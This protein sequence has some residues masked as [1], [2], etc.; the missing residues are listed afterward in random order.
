[1][2]LLRRAMS[3]ATKRYAD[4]KTVLECVSFARPVSCLC[5]VISADSRWHFKRNLKQE[6]H[7]PAP[8]L[9]PS[10][11]MTDMQVRELRIYSAASIV[12]TQQLL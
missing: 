6:S 1:M 12:V 9:K 8:L 3:P 7:T 5:N 10:W 2:E 4:W 11:R